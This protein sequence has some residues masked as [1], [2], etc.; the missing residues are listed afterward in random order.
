MTVARARRRRPRRRRLARQRRRRG[1]GGLAAGEATARLFF[2]L[3]LETGFL[4]AAQFFLALARFGGLALGFF[5]RLALAARF[6]LRLLAATVFF[7][8]RARVEQRPRARLALLLGEGAQDDAGLGRRDRAAARWCGPR[9]ATI[10]VAAAW[11][12]CAASG[13]AAAPARAARA[14]RPVRGRGA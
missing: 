1:R 14:L 7:F 12:G 3:A 4:R 11:R 8:A 5:A 10:G 6:G 13:G 9:G 2:R